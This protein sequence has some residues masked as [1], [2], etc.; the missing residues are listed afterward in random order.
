M[1]LRR[2]RQSEREI[3]R[4]YIQKEVKYKKQIYDYRTLLQSK[5]DVKKDRKF[6]IQLIYSK[7]PIQSCPTIQFN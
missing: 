3:K 1:V 7:D 5:K 4:K 2:G 6:A